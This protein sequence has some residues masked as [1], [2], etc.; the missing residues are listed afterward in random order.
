MTIFSGSLNCG[1]RNYDNPVDTPNAA[2][3]P[4][5]TSPDSAKSNPNGAAAP[6]EAAAPGAAAPNVAKK[7]FTILDVSSIQNEKCTT[8]RA[9]TVSHTRL[10]RVTLFYI[11]KCP[12]LGIRQLYARN[13]SL[14][15]EGQS[16]VGTAVNLFPNCI[17]N[18]RG[19][20]DYSLTGYISDTL[21]RQK[22]ALNHKTDGNFTHIKIKS[23]CY[24]DGLNEEKS[25]ALD[26]LL[27]YNTAPLQN[28][29]HVNG[30]L[31]Y[32]P[33]KKVYLKN[34]GTTLNLDGT[35]GA[36]TIAG[37]WTYADI[38]NYHGQ[39]GSMTFL[40]STPQELYIK[41]KG[42][43]GTNTLYS[44]KNSDLTVTP[45]YLNEREA[46]FFVTHPTLG[47]YLTRE[48]KSI[49]DPT[50]LFRYQ[51]AKNISTS[52]FTKNGVKILRESAR[53]VNGKTF[54]ISTESFCSLNE[55][56][57]SQ[58]KEILIATLGT[59]CAETLGEYGNRNIFT[60]ISWNA[61]DTGQIYLT[62]DLTTL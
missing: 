17:G 38:Y 39:L 26:T 5:T 28:Y 32:W 31:G 23:K 53:V 34:N 50:Y 2:E 13:I 52:Y 22:L 56:N 43:R 37:D 1:S 41:T 19:V 12:S 36:I 30:A 35:V 11:A 24:S 55:Y 14:N 3:T 16:E 57:F 46:F 51:N 47:I 44:I 58:G 62:P 8:F 49:I 61:T 9:S 48:F 33:E 60:N 4:A 29:L 21:T 7:E 45:A 27:E 59:L 40:G 42:Y 18:E 6:G 10:N 15:F 25:F 54:F 20:E